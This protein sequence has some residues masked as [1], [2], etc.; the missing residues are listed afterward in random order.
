MSCADVPPLLESGADMPRSTKA[1]Q[2][3]QSIRSLG[4]L[5]RRA[6]GTS[7]AIRAERNLFDR[8]MRARI[9]NTFSEA[10]LVELAALKES[11]LGDAGD[12]PQPADTLME[13][14]RSLGRFPRRVYGTSEAIR[15]ERYLADRMIRAKNSN[16][17]SEA[18][19]AELAALEESSLRDAAGAPGP[20]ETLM[21]EIRSFGRL[22]RRVKGTTEAIRKERNLADRLAYRKKYTVR[23]PRGS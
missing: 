21:Q 4:R 12:A 11:S 15:E 13:D 8:M 19:L 9:S 17:F 20:A 22:P 3:M 23:H 10:Q 14:I 7:D 5:P 2:L 18:Q 6:K 1:Q 16:T